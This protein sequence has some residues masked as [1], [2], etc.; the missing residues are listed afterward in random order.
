MSSATEFP[1]SI[2]LT[3]MI[4][5]ANITVVNLNPREDELFIILP[6]S[7]CLIYYLF[8]LFMSRHKDTK[9]L[10]FFL[11]VLFKTNLKQA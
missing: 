11:Q 10:T 9:P 1:L 7:A 4:I 5:T 8:V 2:A 6:L 3:A